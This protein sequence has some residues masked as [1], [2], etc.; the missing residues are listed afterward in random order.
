MENIVYEA[1]DFIAKRRPVLIIFKYTP[2]VE[3]FIELLIINGY[4]SRIMNKYDISTILGKEP[5]KDKEAIK[6]AGKFGHLTVATAAAGRGMDIKFDKTSLKNGGLHVILQSKMQNERVYWQCVGRC[7][8]QGQPGSVTEYVN[9]NEYF[10]TPEFDKG[11]EYL[12]RLQNKFANFL[13]T[14]WSWIYDYNTPKGTK[15]KV[16]FGC[17]ID[18]FIEIYSGNINVEPKY[19]PQILTGY[20]KDMILK[21]WGMLYSDLSDNKDN[22]S[23]YE[24]MEEEYENEFMKQLT[25]WIPE[26]C[27]SLEDANSSIDKERFKRIDW[28]EVALHALNIAE[29]VAS[30][31]CPGGPMVRLGIP[32]VKSII[33]IIINLINNKP[34]NW[35]E[36]F[37]DLGLSIIDLKGKKIFGIMEKL[38]KGGKFGKMRQ[39]VIKGGNKVMNQLN[40]FEKIYNRI[41]NNNKTAK[42]I[43]KIE[44]GTIKEVIERRDEYAEKI[45]SIANDLAKGEI[46]TTK[47]YFLIFEG[48]YQGVSNSSLDYINKNGLG[49]LFLNNNKDIKKQRILMTK[50]WADSIHD[51]VFNGDFLEKSALYNVYSIYKK[52]IL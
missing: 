7:G 28:E 5:K 32:C 35:L 1:I 11:Y 30:L 9:E 22:Y 17:S 26:D 38:L 49:R 25:T 24:E 41:I 21:A 14:K 36:E 19:E 13:R 23:S 10:Y 15:I 52:P 27:K 29:I 34:I 12:I 45:G 48:V 42:I 6:K 46:P 37:F 2:E 39:F 44:K 47:I 43:D 40:K 50:V 3:Y 51:I 33:T 18:K 31:I 16:P 4:Y 20:Y 8:R